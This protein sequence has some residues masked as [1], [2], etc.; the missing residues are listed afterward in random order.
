MGVAATFYFDGV[1]KTL[2]KIPE[3]R[4][5]LPGKDSCAPLGQFCLLNALNAVRNRLA[6]EMG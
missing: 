6:S 5:L 1:K 3:Q 4:N 2:C